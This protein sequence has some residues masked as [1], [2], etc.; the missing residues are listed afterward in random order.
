MNHV[1]LCS[2]GGDKITDAVLS[3][4]ALVLGLALLSARWGV[5]P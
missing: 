2:R 5:W 4:C 3:L 1:V